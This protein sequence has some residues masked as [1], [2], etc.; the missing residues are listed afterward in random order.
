M[1]VSVLK[2]SL[3]GPFLSNESLCLPAL[4]L[5]CSCPVPLIP[6]TLML[7][8]SENGPRRAGLET[9]EK[10]RRV[11]G[12][13]RPRL[14]TVLCKVKRKCKKTSGDQVSHIIKAERGENQVRGTVGHLGCFRTLL[15]E[16]LMGR[17]QGCK[18][19]KGNWNFETWYTGL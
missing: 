13:S 4:Y 5:C 6:G 15:N 8:N 17:L 18:V 16:R 9:R 2:V 19:G 11:R 10:G 3:P 7:P 1:N 12:P 14:S